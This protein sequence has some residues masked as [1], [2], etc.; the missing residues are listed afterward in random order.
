MNRS[1]DSGGR[2]NHRVTSSHGYAG[3]YLAHGM[4]DNS[5]PQRS[6]GTQV[7]IA[8]WKQRGDHE[9]AFQQFKAYLNAPPNPDDWGFNATQHSYLVGYFCELAQEYTPA[10]TYLAW[11]VNEHRGS[12][13]ENK[14]QL[15]H[16]IV[17]ELESQNWEL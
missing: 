12:R 8:A 15:A 17:T 13:D 2:W 4:N 3:R 7:G 9:T 5:N 14:S 1:G 11:F 10:K 16:E 6:F